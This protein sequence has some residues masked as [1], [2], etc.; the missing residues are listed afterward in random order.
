MRTARTF[1][2]SGHRRLALVHS[3]LPG[4]N[5]LLTASAFADTLFQGQGALRVTPHDDPLRVLKLVIAASSGSGECRHRYWE[6][7]PVPALETQTA[8]YTGSSSASVRGCNACAHLQCQG[9][10]APPAINGVR[11]CAIVTCCTWNL[12]SCQ[13]SSGNFGIFCDV[14]PSDCSTGKL[15]GD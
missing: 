12:P 1:V 3:N 14:C 9:Q 11:W 4:A 5:S 6:R 13:D 10:S 8:S 15:F 7:R 2:A